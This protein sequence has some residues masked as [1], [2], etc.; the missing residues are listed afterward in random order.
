LAFSEGNGED[1]PERHA[2]TCIERG[3][4]PNAKIGAKTITSAPAKIQDP[5]AFPKKCSVGMTHRFAGII[6]VPIP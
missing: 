1:Q 6:I 4:S 3:F 5:H 2:P